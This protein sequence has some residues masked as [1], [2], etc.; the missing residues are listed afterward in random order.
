MEDLSHKIVTVLLRLRNNFFSIVFLA[1][2]NRS[3]SSFHKIW[4]LF[5]IFFNASEDM[6]ENHLDS[7]L[8]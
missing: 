1:K 5:V 4:Y 7:A 6:S 8:A 3:S 2:E